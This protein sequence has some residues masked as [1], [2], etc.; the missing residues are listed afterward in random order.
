[1][2]DE[3]LKTIVEKAQGE[4]PVNICSSCGAKTFI[5]DN[6]DQHGAGCVLWIARRSQ[7]IADIAGLPWGIT[8]RTFD[9]FKPVKGTAPAKQAALKFCAESLRQHHF[10]TLCG[11]PG[12]GKTH[13]AQAIGCYWVTKDTGYNVRYYQAERMLDKLRACFSQQNDPGAFDQMM[14]QLTKVPLLILDDLGTETRSEWTKAKVD[15]IIDERYEHGRLTVFTT[16]LL[17]KEM[18][19]RVASRLCEGVVVVLDGQDYRRIK[20]A[21]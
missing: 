6:D 3:Y 13:L 20:A 9:N 15:E 18:Q 21:R 7:K 1:M 19:P 5:G 12:T 8:R 10:L 16:N 4:T 17:P 14:N 2:N 11:P